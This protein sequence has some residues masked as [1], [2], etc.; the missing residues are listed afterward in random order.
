[1]P[2]PKLRNV[3]CI[4]LPA[5]PVPAAGWA[6][7][8]AAGRP[9][10]RGHWRH[11]TMALSP[12]TRSRCA[13]RFGWKPAEFG[14]SGRIPTHGNPAEQITG[15]PVARMRSACAKRQA[16]QQR[17]QREQRQQR[18]QRQQRHLSPDAKQTRSPEIG[19]EP[20]KSDPSTL[21]LG[22]PAGRPLRQ[23]RLR[24]TTMSRGT[25]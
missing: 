21:D 23:H 25:A 6:G 10:R 20:R 5:R 4:C 13:E 24:F 1:M 12:Q 8:C 7:I 15:H 14:R 19:D 17:Q 22:V 18:Q 2:P 3:A 9:A 16:H 11:V